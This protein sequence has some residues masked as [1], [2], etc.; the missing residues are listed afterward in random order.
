M[1]RN[2]LVFG[3]IAGLILAGFMVYASLLINNNPQF[4][5]NDV[6]GWA[7]MIAVFALM[8]IGVKNYRDKYN[9]GFISFGK[10]FKTGF[11]IALLASTIY[12]VAGL[13]IYYVFIP[14]WLDKYIEHVMYCEKLKG[15]SAAELTRKSRDMANFKEMYKNPAFVVFMTYMEVLPVGTIVALISALVLKRKP[16][17]VL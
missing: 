3:S 15:A 8:F 14:G 1:K 17:M 13:M 12:V 10:A 11:Y 9:D 2:V 6:A 7:G 4:K 5:S 16:K